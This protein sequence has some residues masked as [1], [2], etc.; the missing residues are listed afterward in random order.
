M[1]AF[2]L[3]WHVRDELGRET[4]PHSRRDVEQLVAGGLLTAGSEVRETGSDRWLKA[5]QD[6]CLVLLV[7]PGAIGGAIAPNK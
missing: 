6:P 2:R 4:G 1:A 7:H 5:G 3:K